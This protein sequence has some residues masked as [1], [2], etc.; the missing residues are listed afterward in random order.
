MPKQER[1]KS[2]EHKPFKYRIG[3]PIPKEIEMQPKCMV[4]RN[5]EKSINTQQ[6]AVTNRGHLIPCCWLDEHQ[7]LNHPIMIE[8]LKVSKISEHNSIE[9]ILKTNEWA[10]FAKNLAENNMDKVLPSCIHHCRKRDNK[11]KIKKETYFKDGEVKS[12]NIV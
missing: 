2:L 10:N 4:E 1:D 8:L 6:A 5:E 9:D 7:T 3:K 12:K 11:D